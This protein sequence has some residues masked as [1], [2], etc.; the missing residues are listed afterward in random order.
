MYFTRICK[1]IGPL[2]VRNAQCPLFILPVCVTCFYL[3]IW[4][5]VCV[6][7]ARLILEVCVLFGAIMY[8]LLAMKEIHHQ[9]FRVFFSTLVGCLVESAVFSFS[10]H[11]DLPV[12]D[13]LLDI[14]FCTLQIL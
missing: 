12:S 11:I 1:H 2:W 4:T 13:T 9:G 8:I 7:Q 14:R 10:L 6:L 5:D 3:C